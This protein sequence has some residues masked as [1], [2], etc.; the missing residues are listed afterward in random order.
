MEHDR[1]VLK[2]DSYASL[3]R[4]IVRSAA[5]ETVGLA[6]RAPRGPTADGVTSVSTENSA[7]KHPVPIV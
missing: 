2:D 7:E 5:A 1:R 3:A 6:P 4:D